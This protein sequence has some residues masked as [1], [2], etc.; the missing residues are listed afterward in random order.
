MNNCT[1]FIFIYVSVSI[2]YQLP[3]CI[4]FNLTEIT[5]YVSVVT[6]A[7]FSTRI[8]QSYRH[9]NGTKA[10]MYFLLLRIA[11]ESFGTRI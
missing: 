5:V 6:K 10:T 9:F 7:A 11:V 1:L 2:D 4:C 8:L 3:E